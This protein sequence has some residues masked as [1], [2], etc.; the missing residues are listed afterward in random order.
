MK[1]SS[2]QP[3]TPEAVSLVC[4]VSVGVGVG[5]G[6]GVCDLGGGEDGCGDPGLCPPL[7]RLGAELVAVGRRRVGV[8]EPEGAGAAAA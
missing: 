4:A 2:G 5:V 7:G 1:I 3:E 6:V 8:G